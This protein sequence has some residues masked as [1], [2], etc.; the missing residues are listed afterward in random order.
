MS[1]IVL[2][3]I[4]AVAVMSIDPPIFPAQYEMKFN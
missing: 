4:L 3:A 1:K 2:L